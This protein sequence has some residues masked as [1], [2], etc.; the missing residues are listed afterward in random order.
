MASCKEC[1]NLEKCKSNGGTD[2]YISYIGCVNVESNCLM[3]SQRGLAPCPFCGGSA[4]FKRYRV[5]D[6]NVSYGVIYVECTRCGARSG[7]HGTDG[8][9]GTPIYTEEDMAALWNRRA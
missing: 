2:E 6:G 3:F 7:Q 4:Q 8:Y 9:Y 1:T 5:P